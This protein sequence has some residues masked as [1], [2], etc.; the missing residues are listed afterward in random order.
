MMTYEPRF[1]YTDAMVRDLMSVEGARQLIEVLP[2]PP[3]A[4]FL[5]RYEAQRRSTRYSTAIEGN[6]LS[7][8]EI[9]E[10]L[11]HSDRVG[12]R[13]QQEVR[14][15]WNALEWL[16]RHLPEPDLRLLSPQD[17]HPSEAELGEP[18]RLLMRERFVRMLHSIIIPRGR[19][20]RP[21]RSSYRTAQCP[22]VDAASGVIEYGPPDP[23]DVPGLMAALGLWRMSLGAVS[24]PVP[25]RAGI[26][27]YQLVT[28]HP[29]DDGNGRTARAMATAELWLG[30]YRMRGFL[31][32]E[33]EYFKDLK[34][35]YENLQM[36]LPMDYYQGRNDADLTPW[37][38]YFTRTLATAA[39]RLRERALDLR[40][41][42]QPQ[43]V[44]WEHLGRRQQQLLMTLV[45]SAS[46]TTPRVFAAA[47][48]AD[49]FMVSGR[50]ARS[51]LQEWRG[52]GFVTPASGTARV[53]LWRLSEQYEGLVESLIAK[54]A[55]AQ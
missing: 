1:R 2:L 20:R 22:V 27:A 54:V 33:E 26:L 47:D 25:I 7:L 40:R 42:E 5:L 43:G 50:T 29:F 15:Y 30:G 32:V 16:E 23:E 35:Y 52:A 17:R 19:G 12:S 8:E 4:A 14:N 9:R 13:Q 18:G 38:E 36:G 53:R 48:V 31:S 10:A 3:D 41:S 6:A 34:L 45:R 46:D 51:W 28:I 55:S 24:L 49:W 37:L 11:A 21:L 39:S 44:P